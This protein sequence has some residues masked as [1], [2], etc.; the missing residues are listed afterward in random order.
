V[1]RDILINT[2]IDKSKDQTALNSFFY[3]FLASFLNAS[4]FSFKSRDRSESIHMW[5][6]SFLQELNSV[7]ICFQ[8]LAII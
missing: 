2:L 8:K 6:I 4:A 1:R 3:Q 5:L 7:Q